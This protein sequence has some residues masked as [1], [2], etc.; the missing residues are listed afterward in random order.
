METFFIGDTH[1]GHSD[2]INFENRP[3]VDINDMDKSLINNW[4]TVVSD[5]DR[6][7]MIG[8]FSFYAKEKTKEICLSLKGHKIL[9]KGNHDT[10]SEELYRE[11]GFESVYSY[12]IILNEFWIISHEPLYLNKNMPYANIYGHVHANEIYKDASSHSFCACVERINYTPMNWQE[13]KKK[14]K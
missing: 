2:V 12:P 3:F 4:N 5:E 9:I 13:I 6:I 14:M 1:F 11:C 7:F 8:D 10:N